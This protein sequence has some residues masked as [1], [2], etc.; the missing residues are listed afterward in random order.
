MHTGMGQHIHRPECLRGCALPGS[1]C[2]RC[3]AWSDCQHPPP[4]GSKDPSS[5]PTAFQHMQVSPKACLDVMQC[6]KS[7]WCT[8]QSLLSISIVLTFTMHNQKTQGTA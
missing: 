5:P 3:I 4:T 2:S 7:I 6:I 8:N 1:T